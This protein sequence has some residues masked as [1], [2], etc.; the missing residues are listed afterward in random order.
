MSFS[1]DSYEELE[2]T[3]LKNDY[4]LYKLANLNKI[5]LGEREIKFTIACL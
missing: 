4:K 5:A 3:I 1:K 2:V